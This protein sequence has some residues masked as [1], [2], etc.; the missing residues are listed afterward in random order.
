MMCADKVLIF[1]I[2]LIIVIGI[3]FY[4]IGKSK[5]YEEGWIAYGKTIN[6][7]KHSKTNSPDNTTTRRSR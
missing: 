5:G 2:F 7:N 1:S 3:I 4:F 6:S